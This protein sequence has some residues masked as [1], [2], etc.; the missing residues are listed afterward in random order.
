MHAYIQLTEIE[1][2]QKSVTQPKAFFLIEVLVVFQSTPTSRN[3]SPKDTLDILNGV[4]VMSIGWVIL[5][6]VCL[7]RLDFGLN[8]QLMVVGLKVKLVGLLKT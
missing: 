6:H 1:E 2:A 5:G 4:R 8:I 3:S 7:L